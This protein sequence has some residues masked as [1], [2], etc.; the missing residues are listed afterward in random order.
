MSK[1]S[2]SFP[3]FYQ[4]YVPEQFDESVVRPFH[5]DA[6]GKRQLTELQALLLLQMG[7]ET[8][9][10]PQSLAQ[11]MRSY[12]MTPIE[13]G[14][15]PNLSK[16]AQGTLRPEVDEIMRDRLIVA[17]YELMRALGT[18]TIDQFLGKTPPTSPDEITIFVDDLFYLSKHEAR[19]IYEEIF[20]CFRYL[21]DLRF[22]LRQLKFETARENSDPELVKLYRKMYHLYYDLLHNRLKTL[23]LIK[24]VPVSELDFDED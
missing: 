6:E 18:E 10:E 7:S 17:I 23:R 14:Y 9:M 5:V 11:D 4:R 2:E 24:S 21:E 15:L 16:F 3:L 13:G 1:R 20:H 19:V 12:L 22:Y 8:S